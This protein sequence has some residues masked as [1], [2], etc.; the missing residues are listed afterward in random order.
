MGCTAMAQ[1]KFTLVYEPPP[2]EYLPILYRKDILYI[3][4]EK[5]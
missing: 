4:T 2:L 5:F 3:D 1:I